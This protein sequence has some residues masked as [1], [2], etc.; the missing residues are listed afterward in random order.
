MPRGDAAVRLRTPQRCGQ[1]ICFKTLNLSNMK[2]YYYLSHVFLF[3][4][5]VNWESKKSYR[6]WKG[7]TWYLNQ[8]KVDG[9]MR[10]VEHWMNYKYGQRQLKTENY[11]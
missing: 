4:F 6:Q 11:A 2:I 10:K 1:S 5:L 9:G 8:F 7:G 3:G